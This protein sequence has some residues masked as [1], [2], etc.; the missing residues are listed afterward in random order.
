MCCGTNLSTE[1]GKTLI[2]EPLLSE[3]ILRP[4]EVEDSIYMF[5]L[6]TYAIGRL[7][8]ILNS[9][10]RMQKATIR[11]KADLLI[12]HNNLAGF[13]IILLRVALDLKELN[14]WFK[15]VYPFSKRWKFIFGLRAQDSRRPC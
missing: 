11:R 3:K 14:N 12:F 10:I 1:I 6:R 5:V 2:V 7:N 4:E 9:G 8:K 15:G 13:T